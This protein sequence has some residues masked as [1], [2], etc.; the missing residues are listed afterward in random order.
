MISN[1]Q[2][3]IDC[4]EKIFFPDQYF[5]SAGIFHPICTAFGGREALLHKSVRTAAQAGG[6]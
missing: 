2:L 1:G 3:V 6:L 5:A 4:A